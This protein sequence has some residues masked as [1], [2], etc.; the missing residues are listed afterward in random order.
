MSDFKEL[1]EKIHPNY[2]EQM[3]LNR[4]LG[5]DGAQNE[6]DGFFDKYGFNADKI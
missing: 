4:L 2:P 1:L 3:N 5:N 6:I